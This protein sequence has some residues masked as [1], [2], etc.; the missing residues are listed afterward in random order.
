MESKTSE[1]YKPPRSAGERMIEPV[2][3]PRVNMIYTVALEH[4]KSKLLPK[5]YS[6]GQ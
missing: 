5:S 1:I 3:H 6:F 2:A 4:S